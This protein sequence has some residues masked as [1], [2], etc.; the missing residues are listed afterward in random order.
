MTTIKDLT[1]EQLKELYEANEWLRQRV[2]ADA[3]QSMYFC[4]SEDAKLIGAASVFACDSTSYDWW[5]MT[6]RK[7]GLANGYAVARKLDK[8]YLNE[9]NAKLYDQLNELADR[10]DEA[11]SYEEQDELENKINEI[12]DEL[13]KGITD[14]LKE[15][16]ASYEDYIQSELDMIS[17]GDRYYSELEL[18][19]DG[20]G[21]K[22][23][24]I[25]Y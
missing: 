25:H 9:E 23:Q 15:H 7:D 5:Y 21:I 18:T 17:S 2:N 10:Y 19:E 11:E 6:P 24:L 16:E 4:Q 8:D 22:E 14:Q 3:E 1:G 12:S 13:A 20:K